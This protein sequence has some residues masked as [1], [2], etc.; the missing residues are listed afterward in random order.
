MVGNNE[1]YR[2]ALD[3]GFTQFLTVRALE[4][5][6]GKNLIKIPSYSAYVR[7]FEDPSTAIYSRVYKNYMQDA[8]ENKTQQLNT[9]SDDFNGAL[10]QGGGYREVYYKTATMLY[11][12]QYVLGDSLFLKAMQHYFNQWKIA[13]PYFDDFRNSII[14]FTQVDLNWFFDEWIETTKTIDYSI[15]CVK[16]GKQKGDYKITFARKDLAQMPL[17]FRVISKEKKSYDFHI[18]NTWF[19]KETA[20][21]VLPKWYGW[22]NKLEPEYTA[23]V[24]IP[25]GIKNVLIDPTHRLADYNM[26]NNSIKFPVR[27]RFDHQIENDPVWEKYELFWRPDIWYNGFDGLKTGI[28]L[29]GNYMEQK[30]IFDATIWYN[31]GLG[32]QNFSRFQKKYNPISFRLE[33]KT[34]LRNF[35]KKL[36]LFGTAK[37]LDGLQNF[38]IGIEKFSYSEKTRFYI[39]FKTLLR[40]DSSDLNYLI[41][42]GEWQVSKQNNTL[43]IGLDHRYYYSKGTGKQ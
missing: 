35:A 43:T 10:G 6:D 36:N 2:A 26:L 22:G 28:N 34:A 12:L 21:T 5:V 4:N 18:P 11:N 14:D 33:Y 25:D 13:H 16:K 8:L 29:N 40:R 7:K 41:Y 19:V 23:N 37:Y 3:E 27:F 1:T 39:Y 9:H 30:H 38:K 42:P 31:T 17:D 32:Q 15:K 20:A 24:S